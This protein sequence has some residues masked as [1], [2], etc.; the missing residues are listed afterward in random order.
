MCLRFLSNNAFDKEN[1]FGYYSYGRKTVVKLKLID[2][3]ITVKLCLYQYY[4]INYCL[5]KKMLSS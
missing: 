4:V 2:T 5:I 1:H 3:Y